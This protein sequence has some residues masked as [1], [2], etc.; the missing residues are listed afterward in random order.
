M[1]ARLDVVELAF[2]RQHRLD[3]VHVH[4]DGAHQDLAGEDRSF[5]G[6]AASPLCA[7][8]TEGSRREPE[9]RVRGAEREKRKASSRGDS[10]PGLSWAR[11]LAVKD[12]P[13]SSRVTFLR[14]PP[15]LEVSR[16][17]LKSTMDAVAGL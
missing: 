7:N 4:V 5:G 8:A 2:R 13:V 6:G 9:T 17:G 11:R 15:R 10:R 16:N 14:A 12:C 1:L 3:L